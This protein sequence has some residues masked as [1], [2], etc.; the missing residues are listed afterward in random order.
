MVEFLYSYFN[1]GTSWGRHAPPAFLPGM[2]QY[3][4]YW[5][6]GGHLGNSGRVMKTSRPPGFDPRPVQLVA[7]RHTVYVILAYRFQYNHI[8]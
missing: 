8:V 3:L 7:S 5:R 4:F 2:T 1:T 6:L